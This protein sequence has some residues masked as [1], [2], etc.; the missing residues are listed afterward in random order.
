M[1]VPRLPG[2]APVAALEVSLRPAPAGIGRLVRPVARLPRFDG[3]RPRRRVRR[4]RRPRALRLG[5][6]QRPD[7]LAERL[8]LGR[9]GRDRL[10]DRVDV[11]VDH[12]DR[13]VD[14]GRRA[15]RIPDADGK[16]GPGP[17]TDRVQQAREIGEVLAG[18]PAEAIVGGRDGGIGIAAPQRAFGPSQRV[19]AGVLAID[20]VA[21]LEE[22]G[23]P[24]EPGLDV[25]VTPGDGEADRVRQDV[26]LVAAGPV[27]PSGVSL[28]PQGLRP[29]ADPGRDQRPR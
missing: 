2:R 7:E 29:F 16:V 27:D 5:E 10:G 19:P 12:G 11:L 8:G 9:M 6:S 18:E 20:G 26:D 21:P 23:E 25:G 17:G 22:L 28:E 14:L 3:C 24:G 15:A 13:G 1:P 4:A